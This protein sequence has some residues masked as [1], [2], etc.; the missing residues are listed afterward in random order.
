[1]F[2]RTKLEIERYTQ[3]ARVCWFAC[4]VFMAFGPLARL[5]LRE[6]NG[7]LLEAMISSERVQHLNLVVGDVLVVK[8]TSFACVC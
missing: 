2:V 3:G 7:Q 5:E 8:A 4:V 1:M 6:D